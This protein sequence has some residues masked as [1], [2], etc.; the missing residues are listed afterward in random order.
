MAKN[1]ILTVV[2]L[3]LSLLTAVQVVLLVG[4]YSLTSGPLSTVLAQTTREGLRNSPLR[5]NTPRTGR[6]RPT[7]PESPA[8]S[9]AASAGGDGYQLAS[10]SSDAL[11]KA[12]AKVRTAV[13]YI[14]GPL[15][16]TAS[17]KDRMGSGIVFDERGYIITN[18]HVIAD[19]TTINV[20]LFGDSSKHVA[21]VVYQS[22]DDDLAVIKIPA[23]YPLPVVTVGNSDMVEVAEEVLAVGCPFNLEQ[24]V[25]HGIVADPKRTVT[26]DGRTYVDLIQTDAAINSGN[27]GGALINKKGEVIGVNVAIYAPTGVHCGIGFAIPINRAKLLMMKVRYTNAQS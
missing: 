17:K 22:A 12:V 9:A 24:S 23:P 2:L 21:T 16:S 11:A 20:S 3:V 18:H 10:C 5:D 14:T 19:M 8:A 15:A 25:S 6:A 1:T 4:Y 7:L 13:V 27:S 26:I